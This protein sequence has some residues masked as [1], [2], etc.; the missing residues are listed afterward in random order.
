M[1]RVKEAGV[2]RR[3]QG[4]LL[5]ENRIARPGCDVTMGGAPAGRVTSGSMGITIGKPVAMAYLSP[6]AWKPGTRVDVSTRGQATPA[7][8][9]ARPMHREGSVKS[10]KPRRSE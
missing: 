4:L 2:S 6:G 1:G 5:E 10:P 7:V 9:T 3:L 8:V